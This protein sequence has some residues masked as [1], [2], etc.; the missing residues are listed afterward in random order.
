M[1]D[2]KKRSMKISVNVLLTHKIST[3]IGE[4]LLHISDS[5]KEQKGVTA[6]D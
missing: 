1:P 3:G 2:D 6:F 5:E 4:M